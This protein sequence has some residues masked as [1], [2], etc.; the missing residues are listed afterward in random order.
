MGLSECFRNEARH[1]TWPRIARSYVF[2]WTVSCAY[3]WPQ[4]AVLGSHRSRGLELCFCSF[5]TCRSTCLSKL[6]SH[7]PVYSCRNGLILRV[8]SYCDRAFLLFFQVQCFN[9][10]CRA[11]GEGLRIAVCFGFH[12]WSAFFPFRIASSNPCYCPLYYPFWTSILPVLT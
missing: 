5:L 9:D 12:L 3:S 10:A 8:R 11:D 7:I 4:D 1:S 6:T 2:C